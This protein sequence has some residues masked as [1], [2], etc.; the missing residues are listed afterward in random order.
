VRLPH[1]RWHRQPQSLRQRRSHDGR[2]D[3]MMGGPRAASRSASFAS[4]P[5]APRPGPVGRADDQVRSCQNH[6]VRA[7]E[8]LERAAARSGC[9]DAARYAGDEAAGAADQRTGVAAT[10]TASPRS[11]RFRTATTCRGDAIATGSQ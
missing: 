1:A 7:S 11:R 10:S 9:H 6:R 5:G 2:G 4:S 8:R 3:D